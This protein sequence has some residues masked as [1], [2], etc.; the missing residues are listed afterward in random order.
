MSLIYIG[1]GGYSDT[2]MYPNG[3]PK[4]Q[5][6]SHHATRYDCVEINSTFYAPLGQRAFL[7]MLDKTQEPLKFSLKLPQSFSHD[8]TG[9]KEQAQAFV[10]SFAPLYDQ[11]VLAPLLLQFPY[12]FWRN[13]SNR[14]YLRQVC[15]WFAG[16]DLAIEFRNPSW[17]VPEVFAYFQKTSLIF[18]NTDYPKGIGLPQTPFLAQSTS[19]LRLH[20][21][22]ASWHDA[23][24]AAERHDYRYTDNELYHLAHTIAVQKDKFEVLYVYFQNTTKAHARHN[25]A[26]LKTHLNC[27]GF[28]T[29]NPRPARLGLFD[30]FDEQSS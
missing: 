2:A 4:S 25:I 3:T 1:T 27:L 28:T 6:L 30:F 26:T 19:Y 9:T 7:G 13:R 10:Q 12:S 16:F 8:L 18:C 29:K 17:H 15:D 20:G 21:R 14:L 5:Y 22:N 23:K 11:G 24:S